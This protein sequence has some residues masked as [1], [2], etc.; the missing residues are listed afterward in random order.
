MAVELAKLPPELLGEIARYLNDND[1]ASRAAFASVNRACSAASLPFTFRALHLRV[2]SSGQLAGDVEELLA[3][4]ERRQSSRYV[5]RLRVSGGMAVDT[6]SRRRGPTTRSN[7]TCTAAMTTEPSVSPAAKVNQNLVSQAQKYLQPRVLASEIDKVCQI[8][9]RRGKGCKAGRHQDAWKPCVALL[10]A[11]PR[12]AELIFDSW[13]HFPA[14]LLDEL[15]RSL[16]AC[17]LTV[18]NLFFHSLTWDLNSFTIPD[19]MALATSPNLHAVTI[20]MGRSHARDGRVWTSRKTVCEHVISDLIAGAAP[21]L[22]ELTMENEEANLLPAEGVTEGPRVLVRRH[23]QSDPRPGLGG[24]HWSQLGMGSLTSLT[25]T[26]TGSTSMSLQAWSRV[27][28]FAKLQHLALGQG[29]WTG[30]DLTWLIDSRPLPHLTSFEIY[31]PGSLALHHRLTPLIRSLPPLKR[32]I[33][34]VWIDRNLWNAAV[35]THGATLVTLHLNRTVDP[36]HRHMT[37]REVRDLVLRCPLLEDLVLHVRR[38]KSDRDEKLIYKALG[39]MRHLRTATLHMNAWNGPPGS[40]ST[41]TT[42]ALER[43]TASASPPTEPAYTSTPGP[44]GHS[45][46]THIARSLLLNAAVD[47][48]LARSIWHLVAGG[49]TTLQTLTLI[50]EP[51]PEHAYMH[52]RYTYSFMPNAATR[53]IISKLARCYFL[54]RP[55]QQDSDNE[56]LI[57]RLWR[58]ADV[59][60]ERAEEAE[61][62]R[63]GEGEKGAEGRRLANIPV[64]EVATL[65]EVYHDIWP[66]KHPVRKDEWHK[67][68]ASVHFPVDDDAYAGTA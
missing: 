5:A 64:G 15:Q 33:L 30:D 67:N 63:V 7:S 18:A 23:W 39:S 20:S 52:D 36:E 38:S 10:R 65:K 58:S 2:S 51:L 68:W 12:L 29:T 6:G 55:V 3:A 26:R 45:I 50:P 21:R 1:G 48:S 27:T 19:E 42:S 66:P 34:H 11:V 14:C 4:L 32:L 9:V 49:R 37:H 54:Q 43:K 13:S 61:M 62:E 44:D 46:P 59:E 22:R 41:S 16:P 47:D 53:R 31:R 24:R 56:P 57:A 35:E 17:K 25:L 8:R 40:V 60:R 28:N